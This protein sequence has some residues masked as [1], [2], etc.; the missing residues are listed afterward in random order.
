MYVQITNFLLA[1]KY[2]LRHF[3]NVVY[4]TLRVF[5][6]NDL[7]CN[8]TENFTRNDKRLSETPKIRTSQCKTCSETHY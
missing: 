7:Q 6:K 3:L 1:F 2:K 5:Q 8:T 4:R